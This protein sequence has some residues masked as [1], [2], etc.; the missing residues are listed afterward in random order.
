MRIVHVA[1][2]A[3]ITGLTVGCPQVPSSEDASNEFRA[4]LERHGVVAESVEVRLGADGSI[5]ALEARILSEGDTAY[6][7]AVRLACTA[8][9]EES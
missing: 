7:P 5:E 2:L 4:C 3:A 1:A 6:E 8:E 9:I